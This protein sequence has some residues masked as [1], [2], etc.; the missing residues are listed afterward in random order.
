MRR[1]VLLLFV[2][3][4]AGSPRAGTAWA[5]SGTDAWE[6]DGIRLERDQVE[7]LAAEMADRTV[8]AVEEKVGGIALTDGQRPAMHEIYRDVALDVYR[9]VVEVVA[10]EDIDDR[11][12]EERVREL[13]LA[14]QRRSHES[15][16]A[17]LDDRQ[18]ALYSA[19]EAAQ[20]EA[21]KS[22][23]WSRGRRRRP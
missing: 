11:Q 2:L 8:R 3:G 21:F 4:F 23:R 19:W 1:L 10:R 15:L 16:R 6:V 7:R 12:K 9:D 14:G 20:I 13:V 22:R 5:Q 18:M 17:V